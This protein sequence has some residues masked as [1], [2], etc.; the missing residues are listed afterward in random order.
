ML[1]SVIDCYFSC[2]FFFFIHQELRYSLRSVEKYA[3]WVR[4]VFI[5]TNGQIPYW[6][7]LDSPRLTV[8]THDVSVGGLT[9]YC[10]LSILTRAQ[11]IL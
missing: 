1:K 4:H 7:N 10:C 6:L 11:A 2:S 8:V 3:P 5:V 9:S